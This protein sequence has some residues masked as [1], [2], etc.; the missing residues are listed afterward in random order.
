MNVGKGIELRGKGWDLGWR[1]T[2]GRGSGVMQREG[3]LG[4]EGDGHGYQG[5]GRVR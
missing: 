1:R 5:V 4:K 3:E 2:R